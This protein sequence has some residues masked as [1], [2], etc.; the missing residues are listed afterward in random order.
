MKWKMERED[1]KALGFGA[2]PAGRFDHVDRVF[3]G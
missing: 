1:G 3:G 2:F